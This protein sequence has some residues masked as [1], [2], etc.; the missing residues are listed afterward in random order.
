[1]YSPPLTSFRMRSTEDDLRS[2]DLA[3]LPLKTGEAMVSGGRAFDEDDAL[4][5][6]P[7]PPPAATTA[8]SRIE[9][10]VLE[11]LE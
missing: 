9:D 4:L 7:A 6:M 3:A 2:C 5:T 1:M 8:V 11:N 10:N